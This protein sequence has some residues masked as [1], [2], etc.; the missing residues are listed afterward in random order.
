MPVNG[1]QNASTMSNLK[2]SMP[3]PLPDPAIA[4]EE[5]DQIIR[6]VGK[7][8]APERKQALM[9]TLRAERERF[10]QAKLD[11][12]NEEQRGRGPSR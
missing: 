12:S 5:V 8:L 2:E 7:P 10:N 6:Q 11:R 1:L 4:P 3:E 9:E